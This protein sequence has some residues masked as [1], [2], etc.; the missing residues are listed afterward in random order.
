[1]KRFL[2]SDRFASVALMASLVVGATALL[3][4]SVSPVYDALCAAPKL[5]MS[6]TDNADSVGVLEGT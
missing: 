5:R 6:L 3:A 1:M 4:D 2:L